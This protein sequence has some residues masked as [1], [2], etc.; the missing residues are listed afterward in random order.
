MNRLKF[1]DGFAELLALF[2]VTHRTFV[3]A[4]RHAQ[5]QRRDRNSPA[6]QNLQAIDE[7]FAFFAQQ[8]RRRNLAIGE[9]HFAGVARAQAQLIFLFARLESRVPFSMMNAE[10]PWLFFAASVTAMRHAD[11][12]IMP[13]GGESLRRR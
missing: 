13:V 9:N 6:V 2:G 8:I 4:L 11:I 1:R 7:A 10:I 3:R 12:A 5:A